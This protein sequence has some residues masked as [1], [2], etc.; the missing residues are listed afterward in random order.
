MQKVFGSFIDPSQWICSV[1]LALSANKSISYPR[2]PLNCRPFRLHPAA[3]VLIYLQVFMSTN[4]PNLDIEAL[5]L[6]AISLA[7]KRRP[8]DLQAVMAATDLIQ[9]PIPGQILLRNGFSRLATLGLLTENEEECFVLSDAAEALLAAAPQ[10]NDRAIRLKGIREAL[11]AYRPAGE[12]P[13]LLIRPE[14]FDKAILG[15]RAEAQLK[16]KNLLVPK[17]KT[18]GDKSRPGQRQR[19][20]I[21][22]RK[23][24]S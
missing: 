21:P 1:E 2:L 10:R 8:A 7:S 3:L 13:G 24:K 6:F 15:H 18:D 19:K 22:A 20:P 9:S 16:V 17:P 5:L 11:A 23:R 12:Q 14:R 4:H